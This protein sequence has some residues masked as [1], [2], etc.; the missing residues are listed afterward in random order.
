MLSKA[1]RE[2]NYA[3]ARAPR[4]SIAIATST[5]GKKRSNHF[6]EKSPSEKAIL[7]LHWR[8]RKYVATKENCRVHFTL[9]CTQ[10]ALM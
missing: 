3:E 1:Q 9:H 6:S 5:Q 2:L 8:A 7:R 10:V 4:M